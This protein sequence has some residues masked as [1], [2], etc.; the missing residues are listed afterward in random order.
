MPR[1]RAAFDTVPL[2]RM[3]PAVK[4]RVLA[5][6]PS[7]STLRTLSTTSM[8]QPCIAPAFMR[9]A[10]PMLRSV[11]VRRIV[12]DRHGRDRLGPFDHDQHPPRPAAE[13]R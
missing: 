4:A 7:R 5:M 3:V 13:T 8:V 11:G 9:R 12:A 1:A 10:P 2:P 6:W